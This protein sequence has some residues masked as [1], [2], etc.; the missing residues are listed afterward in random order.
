MPDLAE[1]RPSPLEVAVEDEACSDAGAH[2]DA[3]HHPM[4]G[5]GS[6]AGLGQRRRVGVVVHPHR[7]AHG[8]FE[9][10]PQRD[11]ATWP[12]RHPAQDPSGVVDEAGTGDPDRIH[13]DVPRCGGDGS[14]HGGDEVVEVIGRGRDERFGAG[15]AEAGPHPGPSDVDADHAHGGQRYRRLDLTTPID[16]NLS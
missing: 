7:R 3:E 2:E 9:G 14:G 16:G 11:L 13:R 15:A 1:V 12:V 5:S 4:P 6:A 8:L 10:R